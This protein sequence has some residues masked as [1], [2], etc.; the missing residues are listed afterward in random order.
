MRRERTLREIWKLSGRCKKA[1]RTSANICFWNEMNKCS[2]SFSLDYC[3]HFNEV[4]FAILLCWW[5][6]PSTHRWLTKVNVLD[7]CMQQGALEGLSCAN[8]PAARL[9]HSVGRLL[10]LLLL[11]LHQLLQLLPLLLLIKFYCAAIKSCGTGGSGL[12]P[13]HHEIFATKEQQHERL[14][15]LLLLLLL[16]MMSVV[17]CC[18]LAVARRLAANLYIQTCDTVANNAPRCARPGHL[19]VYVSLYLNKGVGTCRM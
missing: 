6:Q 17:D 15:L 4:V 5:S 9:T 16:M 13:R 7:C 3:H 11:L 14:E 18:L 19:S 2:S 12:A 1:F 8:P 10:L